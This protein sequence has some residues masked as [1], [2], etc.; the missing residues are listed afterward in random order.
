M[1]RMCKPSQQEKPRP[2]WASESSK[3]LYCCR[4]NNKVTSSHAARRRLC[5]PRLG[6][7]VSAATCFLPPSGE[8]SSLAW[9]GRGSPE[10]EDNS[11]QFSVAVCPLVGSLTLAAA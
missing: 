1:S 3:Q 8:V 5:V 9:S 11:G 10:G 7:L 4:Y 6:R 2:A